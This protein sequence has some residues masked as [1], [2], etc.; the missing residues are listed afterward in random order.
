MV[1]ISTKNEHKY[2]KIILMN[3]KVVEILIK[4]FFILIHLN[5]LIN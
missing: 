4:K 2:P 1:I 3:E 5:I